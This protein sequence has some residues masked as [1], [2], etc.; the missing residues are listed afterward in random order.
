MAK[1]IRSIISVYQQFIN[2]QQQANVAIS[3]GNSRSPSGI[4]LIEDCFASTWS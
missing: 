3:L 1:M 2:G 4:G